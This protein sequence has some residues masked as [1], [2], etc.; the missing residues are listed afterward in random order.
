MA[1]RRTALLNCLFNVRHATQEARNPLCPQLQ[2]LD[3]LV[4]HKGCALA[5]TTAAQTALYECAALAMTHAGPSLVTISSTMKST[6]LS[7]CALMGRL[8]GVARTA[9]SQHWS[10]LRL[11]VADPIRPRDRRGVL[12]VLLPLLLASSLKTAALAPGVQGGGAIS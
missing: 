11:M 10:A 1:P 3:H 8:L 7:I 12:V 4:R 9:F 2:L 6:S 5:A